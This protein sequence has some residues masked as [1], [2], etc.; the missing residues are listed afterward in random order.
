MTESDR[1]L[2]TG[3][4]SG[5]YWLVSTDTLDDV[6]RLCP[7]VVVGKYVAITSFDSGPLRLSDEEQA[8]G[9]TAQGGIAYSPKI[10]HVNMVPQ[11]YFSEL[12]IFDRVTNLGMLADP[13]DNIFERRIKQGQVHAFVNFDFGLHDID[14]ADVAELFWQQ[15]GW[16]KPQSYLAENDYLNFVTANQQTFKAV[17][18]ALLELR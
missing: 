5:Y 13:H 12:Y 8:A 6:L 1:L 14:Y 4:N 2:Y 9:W 17:H 11:E 18:T 10:Q 3:E 15:I 16:I 7:D